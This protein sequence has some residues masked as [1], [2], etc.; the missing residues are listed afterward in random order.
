MMKDR[1]R[2][3]VMAFVLPVLS[4]AQ[5]TLL[6][7][8]VAFG[9]LFRQSVKSCDEF[10]CR[11]NEEEFFPNFD[12]NDPELGKKNFLFLFDYKLSEGKEREAFL[13]EVLNFYNVVKEKNVKLK[14]ESKKWYAELRADFLFKKKKV[15]LGILLQPEKTSKGLPCWMII[16]V[17]G[18]EKI[19]YNDSTERLPI[20]PE[21]HEA[22]FVEIDS[23]FKYSSKDF[24]QFRGYGL[25]LDALSYFFA[26]VES[27]VLT[28]QNRVT[29]QYHFFDVPSYV[30][31]VKYHDRK[32]T[33]TGWLI[34]NYQSVNENE[35]TRILNQL[36]GR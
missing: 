30:F 4:F 19:G 32:I 35:K 23:D 33:N 20:S 7:E 36:L 22:L 1:F 3:F 16:G 25:K 28:F 17:N 5:G 14:Y 9:D 29:M 13:H 12:A 2:F 10:M 6:D 11:F 15:E 24:S 34:S 31:C 8:Q 26:L 21:Q 18:L 27:G